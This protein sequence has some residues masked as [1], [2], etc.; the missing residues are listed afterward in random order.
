MNA[1]SARLVSRPVPRP[2]SLV[3]AAALVSPVFAEIRIES[4]PAGGPARQ[5]SEIVPDPAGPTASGAA[6]QE[7]PAPDLL[8]FRNGDLLHGRLARYHPDEG[9]RWQHPDAAAPIIFSTSNIIE[10]V[11]DPG[12]APLQREHF[13]YITLTNGDVLP[14]EIISLDAET[15]RL[16]T[17]FAGDLAV[18]R[19]HVAR[20]SPTPPSSEIL[21]SGPRGLD[22]WSNV[23]PDG[24]SDENA[25]TY[26]NGGFYGSGQAS[27]GASFDLPDQISIEFDLHW[28]DISS[29]NF[30]VAVF[31]DFA[32]PQPPAEEPKD[33]GAEG[34]K[35]AEEVEAAVKEAA[36]AIEVRGRVVE[37]VAQRA[38][39]RAPGGGLAGAARAR[40]VNRRTNFQ[41]RHGSS[42]LFTFNS[43]NCYLQRSI[44]I[45]NENFNWTQ[46]G[47]TGG[48]L[49]RQA[50]KAHIEILADREHK[51][52]ALVID[53]ALMG[54]WTEEGDFAGSGNS[55]VFSLYSQ[56]KVRVSDLTISRWNGQIS[57]EESLTPDKSDLARLTNGN[58]RISG[59]VTAIAEGK[60][61]VS[62]SYGDMNIPLDQVADVYLAGSTRTTPEIPKNSLRAYFAQGGRLTL[63]VQEILVPDIVRGQNPTLGE[64]SCTLDAFYRFRFGSESD[65]DQNWD[66]EGDF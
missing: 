57:T 52:F 48:N 49:F 22:G 16:S 32:D 27:I 5:S 35:D 58:D 17:W 65:E 2:F 40:P 29:M 39:L 37:A 7:K 30:W 9:V 8:S 26:R 36:A 34:D 50:N 6:A 23:G 64:V 61:E 66:D 44:A 41:N 56:T 13:S 19:S 10:V 24:Q 38:V 4:P 47:A 45:D 3:L 54:R 20:I 18:P 1:D 60:L 33:D 21:Y 25:W 28:Q 15:L 31:S 51:K 14:A 55:V 63:G 62:A 12:E 11:R 59:S 42:Y 43:N 53:G 46:L